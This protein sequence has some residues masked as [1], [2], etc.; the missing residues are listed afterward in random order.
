MF[1]KIDHV[2]IVPSDFE[3]SIAFYTEVLGFSVRERRTVAAPP[4][5]DVVYLELGG[6][7][8]E[9]LE[10]EGPAG[11]VA[12]GPRVGYRMMAV[13]VSDMNQAL[14]YLAGKGIGASVAPKQYGTSWRAEITDPDGI[15]IELRQW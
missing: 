8:L 9:L 5:G 2:E 3:R 15:P 1:R 10:F 7:V 12:P 6:S 4:I 13:E 11:L 14:E